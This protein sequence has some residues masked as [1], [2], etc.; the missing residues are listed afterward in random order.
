MRL[1]DALL[2]GTTELAR[3]DGF[4]CVI[5]FALTFLRPLVTASPLFSSE[6][7]APIPPAAGWAGPA[8]ARSITGG[9]PG[10]GG[11]GGGGPPAAATGAAGEGNGAGVGVG[12]GV[13][14]A[15]FMASLG[16]RPFAFHTSPCGN[17]VLT[18]S[19]RSLNI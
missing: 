5:S 11:G 2:S 14:S 18:Y 9:G 12:E 1:S 15:A 19:L 10:G 4:L 8:G 16:L 17:V 7:T 3:S 13:D 6:K